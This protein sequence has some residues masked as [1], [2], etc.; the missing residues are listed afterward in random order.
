HS[1]ASRNDFNELLDSNAIDSH[2]QFYGTNRLSHFNPLNLDLERFIYFTGTSAGISATDLDHSATYSTT[3]DGFI[4]RNLTGG[5]DTLRP[6]S[7]LALLPRPSTS[8][9]GKIGN[10]FSEQRISEPIIGSSQLGNG[11]PTIYPHASTSHMV[12]S[13]D[14]PPAWSTTGPSTDSTEYDG[15]E[16]GIGMNVSEPSPT[17]ASYYTEPDTDETSGSNGIFRG[18]SGYSAPLD[19]PFDRQSGVPLENIDFREGTIDTYRTIFLQRL[20]DPTRDWNQDTNPYI[21]IDYMPVD[22]H[23][24]DGENDDSVADPDLPGTSTL[25]FQS[26]AKGAISSGRRISNLFVNYSEPPATS[27][28]PDSPADH[29][30]ENSLQHSFGYWNVTPANIYAGVV[31]SVWNNEMIHGSPTIIYDGTPME[32]FTTPA[33]NSRPYNSIAELLM[34]PASSP[35]RFTSEFSTLNY[36]GL[37]TSNPTDV[38]ED[39]HVTEGYRGFYGYTLPFYD[40]TL[41]NPGDLS[42]SNLA[43]RRANFARIFDYVEVP[44]PFVGTQKWFNH[45]RFQG[46]YPGQT[47]GDEYLPRFEP[48]F[49]KIS[50]FRDPGKINLNTIDISGNTTW[51]ALFKGNSGVSSRSGRYWDAFRDDLASSGLFPD[52]YPTHFRTPY[53]G[54]AAGSLLP[55]AAN[56]NSGVDTSETEAD[57]SILRSKIVDSDGSRKEPLFAQQN[58]SGNLPDSYNDSTRNSFFFYD[59]LQRTANLT[60]GQSNVYA[61]WVTVGFFEVD[62]VTGT[63]G[64]EIGSDGGEQKRHRGFYMVDRSRPVLF[65]PGRVDR[66]TGPGENFRW[67]RSR[68]AGEDHNLENLFLI[69]RYIQ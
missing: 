9:G 25:N 38:N 28:L 57:H 15:T 29:Y 12:L 49:N 35:G 46:T 65:Q 7:Y 43:R 55:L 47:T 51:N 64:R 41:T 40:S 39:A 54:V 48:P 42:S 58:E 53:G 4:Y 18:W 8:I 32:P 26:R 14:R 5:T 11:T 30:Q 27:T 23:V 50:N 16:V 66:N 22:L 31:N 24:F 6:G 52:H 67:D 17:G 13:T 21:T 45:V 62:P 34:V 56:Q 2:F 44:S 59:P 20:A 69:R 19:E 68:P 37:P 1:S 10:D 60:T 63:I 33:W 61:I 3:N 36:D